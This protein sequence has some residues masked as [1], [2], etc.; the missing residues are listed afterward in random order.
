MIMNETVHKTVLLQE[1]VDG[2]LLPEEGSVVD[3]TFG[4]GGHSLEILKR[5][6]NLKLFVFDKD[7]EA[8][9]RAEEKFQQFAD[10]IFFINADF[11][12]MNDFLSKEGVEKV[13]G[14]IFDLGFSS[15]QLEQGGR[16][17]S[18]LKKEE[19]ILMTMQKE[20]LPE[21]VTALDI[22]NSWSADSL[23]KIFRG[24]GE[25]KFALRIAKGIVE[26]RSTKKFEKVG[27]LLEVLEKSI[28][29]FAKRGKIHF[30]TKIFQALRIAVNDELRALEEG[31]KAG[32]CLLSSGRRMCVITFHSLED[33]IVKRF[34]A[35]QEKD[36][37]GKRINKKP[38]LASAE[39]IKNN[40]RARSA[41]LRIFEKN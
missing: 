31:L 23:E 1:T 11:R 7:S 26:S 10:R 36:G 2:L 35:S 39:E 19:P 40:P 24:Y 9:T 14:I 37:L 29:S 15:D 17:F 30:A 8:F 4:G 28:P 21:D 16:G 27:D 5:K 22:L 33:R 13:E 20:I 25:E 3:A 6:K 38:I 34:F 18:F 12:K 41:K 32:F